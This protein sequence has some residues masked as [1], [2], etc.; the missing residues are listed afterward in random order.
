MAKGLYPLWCVVCP[1]C[2]FVHT[3]VENIGTEVGYVEHCEECR[4]QF[5]EGEIL[6][7]K[8]CEFCNYVEDTG[9]MV[10]DLQD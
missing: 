3:V 5:T 4:E 8:Q 7:G 10:A 2:G 1:S 6:N 9:R